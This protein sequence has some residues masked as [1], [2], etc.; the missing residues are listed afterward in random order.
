[1]LRKSVY[2]LLRISGFIFL[3]STLKIL[4]R[5]GS[6]HN[7]GIHFYCYVDNTQLYVPIKADDESQITKLEAF[8][9]S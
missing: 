6:I 1:M 4:Y 2:V 8:L 7:C 9:W 3:I 5:S